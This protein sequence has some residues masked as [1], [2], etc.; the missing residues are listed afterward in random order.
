MSYALLIRPTNYAD[1]SRL[2]GCLVLALGATVLLGWQIDAAALRSVLPGLISMQPPTAVAFVLLAAA[3]CGRKSQTLGLVACGLVFA[4]AS[5]SVAEYVTGSTN[6][7]DSLIYRNA[8]LHQAAMPRFPGRMAEGT[9][10]AFLLLSSAVGLQRVAG[11]RIPAAAHVALS[12][13]PLAIGAISLLGYFLEVPRVRGLLGYTDIALPTALG[14][15]T[16]AT[17]VL[18]LRPDIAWLRLLA[19]RG[20]SGRLARRMLPAILLLTPSLAWVTLRATHSGLITVE[21]RLVLITLGTVLGL[22]LLALETG[23]R[24]ATTEAQLD[25]QRQHLRASEARL[26]ELVTTAHEAI[27]TSDQGGTI[28][29][30]NKQ[31]EVT[32]GWTA[33]EAL[34]RQLRDLIVPAR[35]RSAHAAGMARFLATGIKTAIGQRIEVPALRKDGSEFLLEMALSATEGAEGWRFTAMMHDISDRKA[36]SELFETAFDKAPIGVALVGLDGRFLKVNGPFSDLVGYSVEEMLALDFQTI[37]HP[38]DLGRDLELLGLLTAG[39]IPEYQMDKRY[40]RENGS[41]I[42]VTAATSPSSTLRHPT[43]SSGPMRP[44]S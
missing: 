40:R 42:W 19:S 26:Q 21:L 33:S 7:I 22:T 20:A 41:I 44:P 23:R 6:L 17:A 37:T 8:V 32:F 14:L 24:M 4:A 38:D 15:V 28:T 16:L 13:C 39:Q 9:A 2:L 43:L 12:A 35:L 5:L 29:G 34:G 18:M 11:S 36:Q 25:V 10:V 1:F 27:V 30:W 31:A 3:I